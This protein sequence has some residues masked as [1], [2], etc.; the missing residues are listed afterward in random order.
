MA[1]RIAGGIG[2]FRVDIRNMASISAKE[3]TAAA[4]RV[5][6]QA[7]GD[8]GLQYRC[9]RAGASS[10]EKRDEVTQGGAE[11]SSLLD[12]PSPTGRRA[13]ALSP[14]FGARG[15]ASAARSQSPRERELATWP[16][17]HGFSTLWLSSMRSTC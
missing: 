14:S 7:H 4:M 6:Q 17:V 11:V 5:G 1:L 12:G 15:A 8:Q 3:Y 10:R 16:L 2:H 13:E 9:D